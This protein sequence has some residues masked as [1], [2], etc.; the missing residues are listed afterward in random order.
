VLF[1]DGL[2]ERHGTPLDHGL[3]ALATAAGAG[4]DDT[5]ELVDG[6]LDALIGEDARP[7]DVA[8]LAARFAASVVEEL[9]LELP[10]THDGLVEMRSSL[11]GWLDRAMVGAEDAAEALLAVWEA[12]ANAVEHAQRPAEDSFRVR[13]R[14]DDDGRMR[15]EVRD[16]GRWKPGEGSIDR[17]LGLGLMRSL[18]DRV[19]VRPGEDGTIVVLERAVHLRTPGLAA[20]HRR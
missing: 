2:V 12:C 19:E 10:S 14:L 4:G 7:D 13:G 8:I 17:G 1:T 18:M 3:A 16:S 9:R 11:R 15:I 5:E 20:I 6:V